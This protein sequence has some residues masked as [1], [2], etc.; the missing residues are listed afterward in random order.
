MRVESELPKGSGPP[1]AAASQGSRPGLRLGET[2]RQAGM[3]FSAHTVSMGAGFFSSLVMARWMEP[4][5]LGRFALCLTIVVL[6]GLIFEVGIFPAGSRVLALAS[7]EESERRGIGALVL[8]A[9][10]IGVALSLFI[11]IA[12]IPIDFIFHQNVR[13]VLITAALFVFIQ[14]FHQLAEQCCQGLNR[15]RTLSVFQLLMSGSNLVILLALGLTG[16]LSA[17]SALVTYLLAIGIASAWTLIRLRPKFDDNKRFVKLTFK[18]VRSY[19]LNMYVSRITGNISTRFD[20]LVIAYFLVDLAPL[21]MYAIAQKLSSPIVTVARALAITRFRAFTK[22]NRV[23]VHIARWNSA[24]LFISSAALAFVG[25]L[26]LGHMFPKYS[27]AAPLLVPFAVWNLFAGLF[28]PYNTFLSSHG[29]GRELRNITAIVALANSLGLIIVVPMF[30][31]MGAAWTAAAAMALDYAL[32][33][34]Y[35]QRF[36]RTLE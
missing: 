34:Y 13:W 14:P 24:V 26:V 33:L 36:R 11:L 35:Y 5:E 2:T 17:T 20:N 7:D 4:V 25:P 30:G 19:G 12:A 1:P 32:T 31:I 9:I 23:P 6:A 27:Q 28:Q 22:L 15:I 10:G 16:S 8:I 21:G 29:R 3:L 18:E